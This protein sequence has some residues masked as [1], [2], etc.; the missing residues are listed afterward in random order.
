MVLTLVDIIC[1]FDVKLPVDDLMKA[2]TCRSISENVLLKLV[3][4]LVLCIKLFIGVQIRTLLKKMSHMQH[5]NY[6]SS[7]G[8]QNL[9]ELLTS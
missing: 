1:S 2:E 6:T 7:S 8:S 9:K 4:L 5:W 3:Q